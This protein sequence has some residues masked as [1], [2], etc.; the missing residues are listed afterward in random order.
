ML[1]Q[2]LQS[3]KN[4]PRCVFVAAHRLAT[5]KGDVEHKWLWSGSLNDEIFAQG[6]QIG[7]AL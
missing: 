4:E 3:S 1:W 5:L 6:A 2:D 7:G